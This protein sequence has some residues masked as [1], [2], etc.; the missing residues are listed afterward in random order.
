MNTYKIG[1][2]FST[3]RELNESEFT[4]LIDSLLLQIEDPT[5]YEENPQEYAT[6]NIDYEIEEVK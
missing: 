6:S 5:D 3:N 2:T 4:D 1:F